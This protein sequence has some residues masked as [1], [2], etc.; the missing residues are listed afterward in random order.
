MGFRACL[1]DVY[2]TAVRYDF[3]RTHAV[4]MP[5]LAGVDPGLWNAAA[6]ELL[7]AATDGRLTTFEA[8][9]EIIRRAGGPVHEDQ[10]RDL[11]RHDHR[12]LREAALL[13]D[14]T[15]PFLHALRRKGVRTALVSNCSDNTR[16]F[17]TE[18]GL[19]EQVDAVVLSCE[20]GAAKP[21]PS[22]YEHALDQLGVAADAAVFV[23]DQPAYCA[24]AAALGIHAVCIN[25]DGQRPGG[26]PPT[27]A[28]LTELDDL[29]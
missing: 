26:G 13:C 10:V 3:A 14:D 29:F 5:A 24:G 28:T 20:V 7:P 4:D 11:V 21:D 15:V 16:S 8:Y 18:L 6:R 17:L 2:D 23:D 9:A 1:I 22:I 12:L 25:R 27:I 19:V